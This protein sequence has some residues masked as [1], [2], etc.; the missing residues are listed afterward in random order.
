[1]KIR[2]VGPEPEVLL[3]IPGASL[4]CTKGEWLDPEAAAEEAFIPASHVEIVVRGLVDHPDWDVQGLPG[5]KPK[6]ASKPRGSRKP[7]ASTPEP[8]SSTDD[9]GPGPSDDEE[10]PS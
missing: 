2:Y 7:K 9:D 10:Q 3:S 6:K 8:E 1:M 4:V 5:A